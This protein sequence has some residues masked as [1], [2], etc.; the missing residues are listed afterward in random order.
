MEFFQVFL[1]NVNP[2]LIK[3]FQIIDRNFPLLENSFYELIFCSS[4]WQVHYINYEAED[5]DEDDDDDDDG[6]K[7]IGRKT[8][9]DDRNML[10]EVGEGVGND[11]N[12]KINIDESESES[13]Y[14]T[15]SDEGDNNEGGEDEGKSGEDGNK[16]FGQMLIALI[17]LLVLLVHAF[18][19]R[20]NR[21][22]NSV[23]PLFRLTINKKVL[24]LKTVAEC[25]PPVRKV[26]GLNPS[27][28][29]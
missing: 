17:I 28:T 26:A 16:F 5:E 10:E 11:N 29:D 19:Y 23:C 15:E 7:S 13:E 12:V 18:S 25:S 6:P 9:H 20:S 3:A 24:P 8:Q 14:E 21:K 1:G 27:W 2:P 22:Q 4:I